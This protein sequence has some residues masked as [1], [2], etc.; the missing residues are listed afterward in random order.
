MKDKKITIMEKRSVYI[1][2]KGSET[3]VVPIDGGENIWAYYRQ[4]SGN[5]KVAAQAIAVTVDAIFE[6]AWR[7][8]LKTSM[9]IIFRGQEYNITRIDDYEGYKNDLRIYASLKKLV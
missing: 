9:T 7:N 6:I 4:A 5:E 8:D 2:G 3:Q 1:P